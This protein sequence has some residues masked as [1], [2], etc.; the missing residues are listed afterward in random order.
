MHSY[1]G[2]ICLAFPHCVFSN[3][4]SKH[5]HGK[6]HS[7]TG[8]I[9]STFPHCGFSNVSS[10]DL[11]KRMHSHIG[12]ICICLTFLHSVFSNVSSNCLPEKTQ[13][14]ICYIFQ[15]CLH[16]VSFFRKKGL[17]AVQKKGKIILVAFASSDRS[18]YSDSVLLLVRA[19]TLSDFEHFC[20]YIYSFVHFCQKHLG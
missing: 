9:C 7:H 10:N 14:P 1:T 2:Y 8:C 12:C 13:S 18:S 6:M 17:N 19:P 16:C 3:E 11:H 15:N 4:P 5:L 20:Q